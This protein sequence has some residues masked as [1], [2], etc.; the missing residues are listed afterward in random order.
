MKEGHAITYDKDIILMVKNTYFCVAKVKIHT[1]DSNFYL[2]L[3]STD[4]L[5]STFGMV[6]SIVR[7]GANADVLTLRYC[8]SHAIK[9]LNMLSE[10]PTWDCGPRCLHFH[11]IKD[12]NGDVQSMCDHIIP[13][14]WEGDRC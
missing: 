1:P 7:S 9:Y 14:S 11:G 8:L 12:S 2:I 5:E 13:E 6:Q 3:N 4:R 10:H